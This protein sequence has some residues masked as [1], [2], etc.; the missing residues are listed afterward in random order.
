MSQSGTVP[1]FPALRP[2]EL[3]YSAISRFHRQTRSSSARATYDMLFGQPKSIGGPQLP[4]GLEALARRIP[5][6]TPS[7]AEDLLW[8][9][10]LFGFYAPLVAHENVRRAHQAMMTDGSKPVANLLGTKQTRGAQ[11]LLR[12]C[13]LCAENDSDQ[14]GCAHWN[15]IHQA[16]AVVFCSVHQ[17]PLW[18]AP[19]RRIGASKDARLRPLD[20]EIIAASKEIRITRDDNLLQHLACEATWL[21][22][23]ARDLPPTQDLASPYRQLLSKRGWTTKSGRVLLDALATTLRAH[24]HEETL[25]LLGA[26]RPSQQWIRTLT[27]QESQVGCPPLRQLLILSFLGASVQTV[28]T[29]EQD[30]LFGSEAPLP[31]FASRLGPA[32]RPVEGP[33][34]NPMCKR[35]R[36]PRNRSHAASRI[37]F[38]VRVSCPHCG[39]AYE[40]RSY[41][42][43]II[44]YGKS[45]TGRLTALLEDPTKD[46]Q[47]ITRQLQLGRRDGSLDEAVKAITGQ[48]LREL[49]ER[50]K[51]ERKEAQLTLARAWLRKA[52]AANPTLSR[53][54]LRNLNRNAFRN[55][56]VYDWRWLERNGPRRR[57]GNAPNLGAVDEELLQRLPIAIERA[58]KR[59]TR[60]EVTMEALA[61]ELGRGE[62]RLV[63]AYQ[64]Y[65]RTLSEIRRTLNEPDWPRHIKRKA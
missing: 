34:L 10:T 49:R 57:T 42:I 18:E 38:G 28:F 40:R 33:C 43:S 13:P 19:V 7:F 50:Q 16:P 20:D 11:R 27:S 48:S 55:L 61:K 56:Q 63:T 51:R 62:L 52:I 6:A 2:N 8:N 44:A 22:E 35:Y 23:H 14:F 53:T 21:V 26:G 4:S 3:V 47:A 65:P 30:D 15:R 1:F 25:R 24:F 29:P 59:S 5:A 32:T 58:S 45:F 37:S 54:E 41:G 31:S 9:H 12:F 17:T 60:A 64:K 36:R 46:V 39:Y